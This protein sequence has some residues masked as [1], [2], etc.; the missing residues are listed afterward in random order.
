MLTTTT[1]PLLTIAAFGLSTLLVGGFVGGEFARRRDVKE[2]IRDMQKQQK[3][4][5]ARMEATYLQ[6]MENEKRALAQVDSIYSVLGL[7]DIKEGRIR[8]DIKNIQSTVGRL[9]KETDKAREKL[10]E[11]DGIIEFK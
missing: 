5:M 4:I 8:G 2:E 9:H 11:Q 1:H 3:E 6:S 7:L 10:A